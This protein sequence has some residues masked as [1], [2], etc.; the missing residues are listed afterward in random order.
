MKN[1]HLFDQVFPGD[2]GSLLPEI[3]QWVKKSISRQLFSGKVTLVSAVCPDYARNERGFTYRTISGGLPHIASQ[4]LEIARMVQKNLETLSIAFEYHITLADTEFDLPFVV[5][6]MTE[7]D[8]FRFLALCEKS[9]QAIQERAD[10][11]D[12]SLSTCQRFTK[13]FPQWYTIYHKALLEVEH[14]LNINS[15]VQVDLVDKSTGRESLYQAMTS[16]L[17]TQD[18]CRAMVKRQWAQYMAWGK[19][20]TKTFGERIVMMNHSTPN[21][22]RVNHPFSREGKERIPILQLALSTMPVT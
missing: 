10:E 6:K 2:A 14:E 12:V 21:L 5:E 19:L 15:S 13:A 22:S 11:L 4:H 7:G 9:C 18:Y 1:F 20:A 17:V 16:Q 8:P 3:P